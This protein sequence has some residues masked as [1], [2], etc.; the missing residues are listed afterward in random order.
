MIEKRNLTTALVTFF[1]KSVYHSKA[2]QCRAYKLAPV[3]TALFLIVSLSNVHAVSANTQ[4]LTDVVI[5]SIDALHPDALRLSKVP[6]ISKLIQAG[7]FSPYGR[8]TKPPKTL[9]AHTAMFTGLSP[10]TSAKVDNDWAPVQATVDRETIFDSARRNGFR[11]GYFYSKEKLGYLVSRAVDV[12][13]WSRY[14]AIDSAEAFI[15]TPGRH[16]TF[17]HVSG[18]DQAGQA[19]GWLSAEYLEELTFIDD[20]L[21]SLVET[22]IRKQNYLLIVTSDHAGHGKIHGGNHPDDFRLPLILCSDTVSVKRYKDMQYS[23]I[24]LKKMIEQLICEF[25]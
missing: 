13:E 6:T 24:D 25:Q 10:E 11:T 15:K 23:V 22:V 12:H 21:S 14:Y 19:Y 9:I 7:A 1:Q 5:I 3:G 8:S 20:Y 18:L 17:L 4:R 16:F 2:N